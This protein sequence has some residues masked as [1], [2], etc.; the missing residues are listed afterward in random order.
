[1]IHSTLD[2]RKIVLF[3]YGSIKITSAYIDEQGMLALQTHPET[4][5]IGSS[6]DVD[7]SYEEQIEEVRAMMLGYDTDRIDEWKRHNNLTAVYQPNALIDG[8]VSNVDGVLK[9]N[10]INKGFNKD[11][12]GV[13]FDG[14]QVRKRTNREVH[15]DAAGMGLDNSYF[16]SQGIDPDEAYHKTRSHNAAKALEKCDK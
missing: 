7:K 5:P 3:G 4:M 6:L 16:A 9:P 10:F 13:I 1:M 14:D 8:T 12:I 11:E 2:N 15:E